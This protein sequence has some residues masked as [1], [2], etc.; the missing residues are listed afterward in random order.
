MSGGLY[1]WIMLAVFLGCVGISVL[2]W[3]IFR[4]GHWLERKQ[5]GA[6]HGFLELPTELRKPP[7][8]PTKSS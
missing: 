7:T 4:I 1:F 3:I 6:T 8:P 2:L 5:T